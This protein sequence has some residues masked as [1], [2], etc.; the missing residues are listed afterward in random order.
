[1]IDDQKLFENMIK[2]IKGELVEPEILKA[3]PEPI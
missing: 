1:M 3:E 2:G